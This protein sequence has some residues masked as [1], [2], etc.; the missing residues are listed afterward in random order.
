MYKK[1]VHELRGEAA[2]LARVRGVEET[3]R[4]AKT[5]ARKLAQQGYKT[6]VFP[7]EALLKEWR[8]RLA[9]LA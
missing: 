2:T 3:A 4:R 8:L 9:A 5:V 6:L 7:N 1:T